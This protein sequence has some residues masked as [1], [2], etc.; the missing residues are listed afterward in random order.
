MHFHDLLY[1]LH[2]TCYTV[3]NIFSKTCHACS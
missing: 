1:M 2:C 3:L